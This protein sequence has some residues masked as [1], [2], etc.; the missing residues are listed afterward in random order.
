MKIV[1]CVGETQEE[2]GPDDVETGLG[3]SETAAVEVA[4]GLAARGHEVVVSGRVRTSE[5]RGVRYS[6]REVVGD[7]DVVVSSRDVRL[8]K[9]TRH[10]AKRRVLWVHDVHA[11]QDPDGC[12]PLYD[13]VVCPSRWSENFVRIYYSVPRKTN[14]RVVHHGVS[15]SYFL[16][17]GETTSDLRPV[18]KVGCGAIYSSSPDR[19]L[20][21]LLDV[22]PQIREL[23]PGATLDVYYGFESWE[24]SIARRPRS[25]ATAELA[26]V[27]YLKERLA[28]MH[29]EGVNFVGR[30]GQRELARAF[31]GARLWLYPTSFA[32]TFCITAL[33]AQAAGCWPVTSS[34]GALSE[35]VLSGSVVERHPDSSP[36][37]FREEY[38]AEVAS[39]VGRSAEVV[40][41]E[42]L[43]T[44]KLV[45][46][47]WTWDRAV[48]EWD[49]LLRGLVEGGAS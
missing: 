49:S 48:D 43:V 38:L 46:T 16:R 18:E 22:W 47:E 28:S 2:W 33:E 42:S 6:R 10:R 35:T 25:K 11:G 3:G 26:E 4:E 45:L 5:V 31:L 40:A 36:D 24:A 29:S 32:E 15:P 30:V 20:D 39:A 23:V 8:V 13:A 17:E 9:T 41:G 27:A 1:I 37:A 12:L 7:A 44:R 19:G 21:R 34:V 14:V